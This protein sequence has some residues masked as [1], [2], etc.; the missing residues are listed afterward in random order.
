MKEKQRNKPGAGA[1]LVTTDVVTVGGGPAIVV[2]DVTPV[3]ET[4]ITFGVGVDFP[5]DEAPRPLDDEVRIKSSGTL[6]C[7]TLDDT[8]CTGWSTA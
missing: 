3:P 1:G 6:V 5:R 7:C 2:A 4:M 8:G